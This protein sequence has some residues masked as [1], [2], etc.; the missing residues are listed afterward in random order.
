MRWAANC[1]GVNLDPSHLF[2]M[3]ADPVEMARAL[4]D[5]IFHVHIKD[6]RLEKSAARNT[7]L[8]TK[9]V[10][11]YGGPGPGTSSPPAAA[12]GADWWRTFLAVLREGGYD[13]AVSI[14]QED[15]TVPLET[16]WNRRCPCSGRPWLNQELFPS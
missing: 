5:R 15:Y 13:G 7:L 11:E 16:A 6:V 10:L 3:G 8:D 9:G 1:W 2:W 4:A 14:E 12:H